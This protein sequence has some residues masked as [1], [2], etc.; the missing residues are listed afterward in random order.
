MNCPTPCP[1]CHEDAELHDM[2]T[3]GEVLVCRECF[4]GIVEEGEQQYDDDVYEDYSEP[5]GSCD[6]CGVD[7]YADDIGGLCDQCQWYAE[8]GEGSPDVGGGGA[9]PMPPSP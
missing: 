4:A 9:M 5:T 2:R 8:M 7:I 1:W 6:E 3:V